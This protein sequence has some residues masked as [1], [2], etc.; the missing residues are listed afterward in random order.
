[1]RKREGWREGRREVRWNL[2]KTSFQVLGLMGSVKWDIKEIR[3]QHSGYV[4]RLLQVILI[5]DTVGTRLM[6]LAI[7]QKCG[8]TF[9]CIVQQLM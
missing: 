8:S 2:L 3:S 5:K 6:V 9:P 7:V 4:D 1:M